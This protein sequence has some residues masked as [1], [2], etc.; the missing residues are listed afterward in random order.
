M[1]KLIFSA[2]FL[3]VSCI[4]ALFAQ[5]TAT[6]SPVATSGVPDSSA[7]PI[8]QVEQKI[9]TPPEEEAVD[10]TGGRVLSLPDTITQ[11]LNAK[12]IKEAF[13]VFDQ[14]KSTLTDKSEA[15]IMDLEINMNGYASQFD[16]NYGKTRTELVQKIKEKCPKDPVAIR[17]E[18]PDN[19]PTPQDIVAVSTKM[20]NADST[21][22]DA[23]RMRASALYELKQMDACCRDIFKLPESVQSSQMGYFNCEALKYNK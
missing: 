7:S 19:N 22:L 9:M 15:T 12:K 8:P 3:A 18:L 21:Y 1:K 16:A 10:L 4:S 14:Y 23:Y 5:A 11:L 2:L 6:S 13:A 20:I 17:Y